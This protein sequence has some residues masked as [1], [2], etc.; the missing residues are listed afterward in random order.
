[1][2]IRKDDKILDT[3]RIFE[4]TVAELYIAFAALF[5]SECDR[6]VGFAEEEIMHA[7]WFSTLKRYVQTEVI[8]LNEAK[9]SYRSAQ[10]TIEFL[11]EQIVH[12]RDGRIDLTG[13]LI[14]ALEIEN[15]LLESAFLRIFNFSNPKAEGIRRK[16]AKATRAHREK[17]ILW[18]D[19]VENRARQAA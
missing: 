4:L 18:L 14:L 6:W 7:K 1:M 16:L 17:F 19:T 11:H 15:S 3:L 12:A 5:P 2:N 9:I 13:A 10:K 8:T